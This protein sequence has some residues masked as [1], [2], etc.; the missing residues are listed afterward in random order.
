MNHSGTRKHHIGSLIPQAGHG[1]PARVGPWA[2]VGL[3]AGP[4]LGCGY[5][6]LAG[7]TAGIASAAFGFVIGGGIG[8][9]GGPL[10]GLLIGLAQ[11]L[12]RRTAIPTPVIA[13]A[14]TEMVLLPPQFLAA[15]HGS[16]LEA[17]LFV[18][19]PSVLSIGTAA[20]LGFLLP[21]AKR[22]R[23]RRESY[24][25]TPQTPRNTQPFGVTGLRLRA[26]GHR[27]RRRAV[28]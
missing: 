21:S 10:T 17:A 25:G 13:V 26:Y 16:P 9:I 11:V 5:G 14:V 6:L 4:C 24:P 3:L 22:P 7:L 1:G 20:A 19:I 28:S 15:A 8:L 27:P 23:R 2:V 12:L 18:Y